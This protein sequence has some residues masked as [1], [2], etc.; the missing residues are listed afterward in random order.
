MPQPGK[1]RVTTLYDNTIEIKFVDS[2]HSYWIRDLDN[3]K[4]SSWRRVSGSTTIIGIMDKSGALVGWAVKL[5]KRFLTKII[6]ERV[7]TIY[8]I[9]EGAGLHKQFKETAATSGSLVHDWIEAYTKGFNPPMPDQP[10]VLQGVMAFKEWEKQENVHIIGSETLLY[11]KKYNFCGQADFIFYKDDPNRIYLGDYK[12]SNGLYSGV[13]MQTASYLRAIEEMGLIDAE[14][15][16]PEWLANANLGTEHCQVEFV[17]RYALRLEKR[18]P[19]EFQRDMEEKGL[20]D[21]EYQMFEYVNLDPVDPMEPE[22]NYIDEDF[23][24]FLCARGLRNWSIDA[25]KRIKQYRNGEI[26]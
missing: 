1:D 14:W 11:S 21:I 17:G 23:H 19:E 8:D 7:I 9:D 3:G 25:D 26:I 12:T 2:N 10:L 24:A 18:S 13:M 4:A 15:T 5:F 22:R 16:D 20:M 6:E